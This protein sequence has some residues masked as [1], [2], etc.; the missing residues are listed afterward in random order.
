ML[1]RFALRARQ[2]VTLATEEARRRGHVEVD[3][4]HVLLGLLLAGGGMAGAVFRRLG[5]SPE[6]LRA[7]MDT[8]T[9]SL[10]AAG[11]GR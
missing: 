6:G 3:P 10:P 5:A 2:N 11:P 1:E 9:R 7:G 8:W 4:E